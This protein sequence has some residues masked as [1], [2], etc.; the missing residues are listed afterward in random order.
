MTLLNTFLVVWLNCLA[1]L[2][3]S[4]TTLEKLYTPFVLVVALA[5][6]YSHQNKLYSHETKCPQTTQCD[7]SVVV[8]VCT[9]GLFCSLVLRTRWI[10][11]GTPTV[12]S[13][14]RT[15][16]RTC[17][18]SQCLNETNSPLTVGSHLTP[19]FLLFKSFVAILPLFSAVYPPL[20]FH[21][22]KC[23][24]TFQTF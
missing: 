23:P 4:Y 17:S 11:S 21:T 15:W 9:A 1:S 2:F 5:T 20:L 13:S 18:A 3:C 8:V 19:L 22:R 24:F 16:S 10:L 7:C 6:W 12:S 14:S